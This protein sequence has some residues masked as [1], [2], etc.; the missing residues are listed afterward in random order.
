[1]IDTEKWVGERGLL[2]VGVVALILAAGYLLK[3]SFDRG[4]VSPLARCIGGGVAGA[5]VGAL[6]WRLESRYRTYGA[7]LVGCGAAIVYLAV[8]AAVRQYQFLSP[9]PGIAV[10][11]IVSLGLALIAYKLNVEALGA[12]AAVGAFFAPIFLS[13]GRGNA[14]L[15]LIYLAVM[16]ATLGL[17]A[18]R[19]HWRLAA[20]VIAASYFGLGWTIG[21]TASGSATVSLL[22][23]Y[24]VAGGA[25]G[26]LL[27]LRERWWEVRA[28]SFWGGWALMASA[29]GE[30]GG[31]PLLLGAAVMALPLWLHGLRTP[32]IWPRRTT[33][34]YR[35]SEWSLGE[36][37]YFFVTPLFL[38]WA[39]RLQA[40]ERFDAAR[41]L[42]A[43]L[44]GAG[45]AA[46]GYARPRPAF[47]LV[48]AA[49]LA[50]AAWLHWPGLTAVWALLGLSAVWALLDHLLDRSDGR[51]YALGTL[52]A[53]LLHLLSNDAFLRPAGDMAFGGEWALALWC[54]TALAAA[55]AGGLWRP[56]GP[57]DDVRAIRAVLWVVTGAM[58]LFGV[59]AEIRRYFAQ[60]SSAP[61]LAGGL[62]VSAWWLIFATG[63][64]TLGFRRQVKPVRQFGLAVAGL[65]GAKVLL[66]DLSSLDAL[67][68]VGSV[69]ILGLASLLVAYLYHRQ[70]RGSAPAP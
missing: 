9:P 25:A 22:L 39:I 61:A 17:V 45:Y 59:T 40:P 54:G 2:A 47:A 21:A 1:M 23:A 52:T 36:A 43:A 69:F 7:A 53:A 8:W 66:V 27:G 58:A 26:L 15:L 28:L 65:A 64:V 14:N 24:G 48:G 11:A 42:A 57:P 18:A 5:T 44:V 4:W 49:A 19:R 16:A 56:V 13:P 35:G 62:A 50:A 10:L 68:R 3:L 67:Y 51:W 63:L 20:L 12:T 41:G 60:H 32:S 37:V 46:A 55:L 70:A 6:G 38:A 30:R 29:T 31:T 33:R 34:F